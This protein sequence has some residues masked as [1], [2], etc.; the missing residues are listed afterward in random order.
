MDALLEVV[1]PVER[2]DRG[3]R[4]AHVGVGRPGA[5]DPDVVGDRAAEQEPLLRHDDD[6]LAQLVEVGVAEVDAAEA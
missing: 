2:A 3:Q 6:P 4:V 1:E 5:G